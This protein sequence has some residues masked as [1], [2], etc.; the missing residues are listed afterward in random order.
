MKEDE[1]ITLPGDPR[2]TFLIK[3]YYAY[4]V[5][6]NERPGMW[7]ERMRAEIYVGFERKSPLG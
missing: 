7:H 5:N 4:K 6:G 1:N 2:R 3:L